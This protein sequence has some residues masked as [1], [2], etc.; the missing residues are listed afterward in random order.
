MKIDL[1]TNAIPPIDC[2]QEPLL[3]SL[4]Y[5]DW[6]RVDEHPDEYNTAFHRKSEHPGL[7]AEIDE[8]YDDHITNYGNWLLLILKSQ[9]IKVEDTRVLCLDRTLV[10]TLL[11]YSTTCI[12][13][14][15]VSKDILEDIL[16][17]FGGNE[18]DIFNG[19]KDFFLRCDE[20]SAKDGV[21]ADRPIRT[22]KQV[23]THI[24]TSKRMQGS[25]R[26]FLKTSQKIFRLFLN[27]W[28]EKMDTSKEFR[29][30]VAPTTNTNDIAISGISQYRY[31]ENVSSKIDQPAVIQAVAKEAT[32]ILDEIKAFDP[33]LTRGLTQ[34]FIFDIHYVAEE[35]NQGE[36]AAYPNSCELIEL[37]SFGATRGGTISLYPSFYYLY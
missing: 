27:P 6:K 25:Y 21:Y 34:G 24:L 23:F 19:T 2:R 26:R 14:G 37:N 5:V 9:R 12:L 15:C 20:V 8:N 30:F 33:K 1:N 35:K 7:P 18:G 32:R 29:V 13:R 17:M 16:E 3:Y 36:T 11:E 22:L 10:Q 28:N 31:W 4:V